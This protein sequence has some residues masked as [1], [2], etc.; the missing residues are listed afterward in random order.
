MNRLSRLLKLE[1]ASRA[2]ELPFPII[3]AKE[4]GHA[5]A[6]GIE[7]Q[8]LDAAKAANPG[9]AEVI[10]INTVENARILLHLMSGEK[11]TA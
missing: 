2:H 11:A 7:Y 4:D 3:T 6:K 5:W 9:A 1:Q 8:T 10:N